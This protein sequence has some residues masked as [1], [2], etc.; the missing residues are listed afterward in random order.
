MRTVARVLDVRDE[1]ARLACI[2]QPACQAC[3]GGRGCALRWLGSTDRSGLEVPGVSRDG[4]ALIAGQTVTVEVP[5]GELLR[6]AAK[7]Y[8]LPL[9]GLLIGPA[10]VRWIGIASEFAALVAAVTGV[11]LGWAL[12]RGWVRRAPPSF[13]VRLEPDANGQ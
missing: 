1:R 7:V 11:V 8:L 3:H 4:S 13:A 6:S 2:E 9:A 10:L 5:D 12:A